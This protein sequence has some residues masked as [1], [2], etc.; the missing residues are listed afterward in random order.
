MAILLPHGMS[1][2]N[3]L[4]MIRKRSKNI[5]LF[6]TLVRKNFNSFENDCRV[7]NSDGQPGPLYNTTDQLL[8][9][10]LG[11]SRASFLSQVFQNATLSSIL[12]VS[13]Q[14]ALNVSILCLEVNRS[15]VC[16]MQNTFG[17][18]KNG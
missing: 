13:P 1:N 11:A 3:V 7:W 10:A 4:T 5:C 12:T 14:L 17:L 2:Y 18:I 8:L 6:V 16:Y 9:T 15:M